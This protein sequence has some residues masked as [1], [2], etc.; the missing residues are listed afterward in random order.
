MD[1]RARGRYDGRMVRTLVLLL[2]ASAPALAGLPEAADPGQIPAYRLVR[3]DVAVAGQPAPEALARL[4]DMG[5]R[6]VV[7]MRAAKEGPEGE[8]EAVE[9]QGLRYVSVPVTPESF[10]LADVEAV[11]RVL[12]DPASGPVLLHCSSSNRVGGAWAV[13]E[14]RRGRSPEEA[15]AAGRA[16]GL[17]SPPMEAAVRRLLGLP[18]PAAVP[19]PV[20]P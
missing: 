10:S 18:E 3:P 2:L 20:K 17:H 12:A 15:L 13:L 8:R 16:A 19:P 5:F 7:N 11:E 6:T 14:S 4:K 9:A 1:P